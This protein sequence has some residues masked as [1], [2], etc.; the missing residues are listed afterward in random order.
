MSPELQGA[1]VLVSGSAAGIGRAVSEAFSARGSRLALV[2]VDETGLQSLVAELGPD[3]EA[4]QVVADV[5]AESGAASAVERAVAE[6]GR[7]DVLVNVVGG[8]RPGKDVAEMSPADW[9]DMLRFNLTSMFLMCHFAIPHIVAAGGGS[10]INISS[11]AGLRGMRKNPGYCAAKAGVVGFT[12]ALAADHGS[13]GIRVN[14]IAPGPVL[15]PL[16]RRNRSADEIAAMGGLTI[17]GRVA[18]PSEI[19]AAVVFLAGNESSFMTGQT[20]E[21]DGGPR[22]P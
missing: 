19:A 18:D 17:V 20:L 16:M 4:V 11:G 9:D 3:V 1:A 22:S 12:K 14:A 15:T 5:T 13:Q 8:S 2:D 6:L 10:V 21:V 7:V